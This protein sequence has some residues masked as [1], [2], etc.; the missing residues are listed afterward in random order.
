MSNLL[1]PS[2]STAQITPY[3]NRH[4][5]LCSRGIQL[6]LRPVRLPLPIRTWSTSSS[7][8]IPS[9]GTP[10]CFFDVVC[11]HDFESSGP[12]HL[13]SHKDELL[14]IAKQEHSGWWAAIHRIGWIPSSSAIGQKQDRGVSFRR[15]TMAI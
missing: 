3:F 2:T 6:I 4:T 13:P 1:T 10:Q 5:S 8:T 15:D 7:G 12:D 11:M 14:T 9:T